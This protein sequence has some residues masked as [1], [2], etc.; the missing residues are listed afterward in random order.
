M[1]NCVL[2]VKS[3]WVKTKICQSEG[4]CLSD[5]YVY[6]GESV[7]MRKL[8]A[9]L[10]LICLTVCLP[11]WAEEVEDPLKTEGRTLVEAGIAELAQSQSGWMKTM[12]EH[13]EVTSVKKGQEYVT[14]TVT[15]PTM[16]CG[17]G[18]K[19]KA[20]DDVQEYLTRALAPVSELQDTQEF[21]IRISI[22]GKGENAKLNW[23]TE[24]SL[25]NYKKKVSGMAST[26]AKTYG[27]T[28][29]KKA[30]GGYLLPKAASMPQS[31]PK[32]ALQMED[33][34]WYCNAVAQSL[35]LT[36]M[37]ANARLPYLLM[38]MQLSKVDA[39]ASIHDVALTVKVD[40]WAI[41]LENA[42]ALA[43]EA[44]Q[45][46]MG[47]PEMTRE[48]IESIFISQLDQVWMNA[49]YSEKKAETVEM[50]VDLPKVVDEGVQTAE[51]IMDYL[52]TY[53]EAV[54]AAIDS[55]MAY[56]ATLDYYPQVDLIDTA[57]LSGEST[58]DGTRVYFQAGDTEHG[59]VCIRHEGET[60]LKGFVHSGTRLMVTLNPGT[61]RVYCSYGPTW[62]GEQY[63]FGKECFCGVFDLEVPETEG[64]VRITLQDQGGALDVTQ[65]TYD[66]F[67]A[68]IGG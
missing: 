7:A 44:M 40:D 51:Q 32:T 12:M 52:R 29:I 36:E 16:K 13:T 5:H 21:A 42:D 26:A 61:Y 8:L 46:M 9:I 47:V 57:V 19:E 23:N 65:L 62:F 3:C 45:S 43:R 25:A 66:E 60:L 53:S 18:S 35:G 58:E 33:I 48:E 28:Q 38:L 22:Q 55:L 67:A 14:V 41:M 39:S 15:I 63:A 59:Y 1:P 49:Y 4:Q 10:L 37:Q 6:K 27:E 2:P 34:S 54:D 20:G 30:M 50:R 11:A 56:G 31:K 17:V 24:K 64:N 68:V